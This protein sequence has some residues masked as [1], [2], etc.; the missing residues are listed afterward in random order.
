[1]TGP[2]AARVRTGEYGAFCAA[3]YSIVILTRIAKGQPIYRHV[4]RKPSCLF[5]RD[6][7]AFGPEARS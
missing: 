3:C 4:E 5:G 2:I 6:G 7:K 1:M